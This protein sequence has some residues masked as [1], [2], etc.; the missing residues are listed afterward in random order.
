MYENAV[1]CIGEHT[2]PRHH[3]YLLELLSARLIRRLHDKLLTKDIAQLG[4]ISI[5]SSSHLTLIIV[6]V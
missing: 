2:A 5:P 3:S 4:T 1:R 6:V